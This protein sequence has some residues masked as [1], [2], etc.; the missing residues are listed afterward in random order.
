MIYCLLYQGLLLSFRIKKG[1][2][3]ERRKD[4]KGRVLQKGES[5]RKDLTYMYR[6]KDL[7]GKR[8]SIYAKTLN[9]LRKKEKELN[10]DL[11]LGIYTT[12][13]TLNELF[14]RYLEQNKRLK[15]RTK[16]KYKTEYDRWIGSKWIGKRQIKT[17]VK[18]DIAKF[19]KE[20]SDAGY[21]NGTIKCIHK[22]IHSSL[23]VAFED[24]MIRKNYSEK[25]IEPY[26]KTESRKPMTKEETSKF[27]ETA[28][29]ANFGKNYLLA[30]KLMLLT[31]MRVGEITG[32]TWNDIHLKERYIDVNHQFVLGD[33]N[34]RTTYHIDVTKTENGKRKVPISNDLCN[35]I[36]ELK[37]ETYFD[38]LKFKSSVDGYSGFVIHTR[39]GLPVLTSRLN[40]Y[41]NRIVDIYNSTHEDQLP[42]ITCHTCRKTFCTRLAEMNISPHALQKIVG[43]GSYNTTARVYISVEDD[44]VNDEFF[45]VMEGAS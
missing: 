23:E 18:S 30:F 27:L 1:D 9:E 28:K 34:S 24:D 5:Q 38:S 7:D 14:N 19:Y 16:H 29:S 43:H 12:D 6:Y 10:K 2:C 8:V 4:N 41:S 11:E 39:S 25:C 45:R 26:I 31:G 3:M 15:D 20:M 21:S 33:A 22:Y 37:K 17:I 32:L 42:K 40:E 36:K 13:I 44:F 35:L